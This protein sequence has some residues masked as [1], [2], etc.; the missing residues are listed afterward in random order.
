VLLAGATAYLG[1]FGL[2]KPLGE[3]SIPTG[4]WVGSLD[5]AAPEQIEGRAVDARADVYALG[6]VLHKAI[7][8]SVPFP[9]ET[10]TAAMWAH[11]HEPV[12]DPRA[13][14]PDIPPGF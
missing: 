1:D 6:C 4:R 7:T 5:Y 9:R 2:L 11:V 14:R 8:A 12:P 3:N 13:L 10:P